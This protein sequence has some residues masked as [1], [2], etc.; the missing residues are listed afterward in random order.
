MKFLLVA[1]M[2]VSFGVQANE[3]TELVKCVEFVSKL[4][5]KKYMFNKDFKGGL[6]TTPNVEITKENAD[7]LFTRILELN[8]YVRVP[9]SV[10]DTYS[11]I[12]LRDIRY[13]TLPVINVDMQSAPNLV[14]NSDYYLMTYKFKYHTQGQLRE[15]SN[16]I[17][18]F[19]SRYGRII[20]MKGRGVII[21]QEN[22]SKLK[23]LYEIIKSA[24]RELTKE[25]AQYM[26]D[27]EKKHELREKEDSKPDGPKEAKDSKEMKKK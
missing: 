9:T 17:R 15:T 21:V 14:E 24:D 26:K 5:G 20:E 2:L 8:G 22:A 27:E 3:C 6:Q 10:A 25:E 12:E 11:L 4:T 18:P 19:M 16:S 7:T 1:V 13:E 23:Q